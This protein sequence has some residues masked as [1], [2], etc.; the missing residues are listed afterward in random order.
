M[1][2]YLH[3]NLWRGLKTSPFKGP[4]RAWALFPAFAAFALVVGFGTDLLE[5]DPLPVPRALLLSFTLII[6]PSLIEEA[7]FRG[8]LIPRNAAERGRAAVSIALSTL[9]FIAWHPVNALVFSHSAAPIFLDP[10]FLV[11]VAALGVTCGHAYVVSKSIWIPVIIHWATVLT[12]VIFLGG[13][14][15][16]LEL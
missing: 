16:V 15:L 6:F 13:R 7:F 9:V 4:A 8:V 12:W 3:E 10:W 14:N 11:I 1:L 2:R 5:Y